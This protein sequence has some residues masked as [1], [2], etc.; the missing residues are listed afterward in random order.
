MAYTDFT[1]ETAER[2]LGIT[3]H[4]RI[5]FPDLQ[6]A[7]VLP[8]LREALNYGTQLALLSEKA[9]SEFIVAPILVAVRKLSGERISILSGERLD[10]DAARKLMGECDFILSLSE[11]LPLLRAP[12]L[13][14][15]EAKRHDIESGLGQC[16]AQMVA[17]QIFNERSGQV[18]PAAYGCVT[19]GEAWQFLR[20]VGTELTLDQNRFYL[21]NVGAILAAFLAAIPD[22]KAT[23]GG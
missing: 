20:L 19:T 8:W 21:D 5:L 17:V 14:I 7:P 6:P 23:V 9:R 16:A 12:L 13:T 11:P 10:V 1:L 18:L 2:E 15:V 3:P 22:A 4:R